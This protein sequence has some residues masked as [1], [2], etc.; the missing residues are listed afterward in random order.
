MRLTWGMNFTDP[1]TGIPVITGYVRT[2]QDGQIR[3][4]QQTGEP[5]GG[6]NTRPGTDPFVPASLG[7][8]DPGLPRGFI[9]TPETGTLIVNG[10]T[11]YEP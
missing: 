5:Q 2:T 9:V 11:I 7:G 10:R 6:Y 4:V 3:V 1:T 8:D